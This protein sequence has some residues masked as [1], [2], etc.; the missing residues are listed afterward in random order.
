MDDIPTLK[1]RDYKNLFITCTHIDINKE[2][3]EPSVQSVQDIITDGFD[4]QENERIA[5]DY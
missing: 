3:G 5:Y 2:K 4:W 1:G